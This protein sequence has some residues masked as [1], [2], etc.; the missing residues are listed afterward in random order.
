M[1]TTAAASTVTENPEL[2]P[3]TSPLIIGGGI[4][5]LMAAVHLAERGL[6]PLV[7]EA[8]P[9]RPGG[10]LKGGPTVE[11]EHNGQPWRFPGEHGVHGIWSPY[12]NFQAALARHNLRPVFVP[13]REETWI[14]GR[15]RTIRKAAIGSAIRHS[16][17][18]A[19]FHYLHLFLR[20]RFLNILTLRDLA[21]MF[22]VF[23]GLMSAMSIDPI[24]EQKSLRGL[25]LADFTAGWSP[26]LASFFAG[27]VRSALAAHPTE[28]PA[29]GFIA[30]LRFYT[31]LRRDAWA[32]SYLPGSGGECV[33][34]P[35]ATLVRRLGGEV[36]LG[37]RVERLEVGRLEGWK[38]GGAEG[39]ESR[40]KSG[41]LD[42]EP[43]WEVTVQTDGQTSIIKAARVILAVDAPAAKK[44]LQGSPA[45]AEA[46]AGLRFPSGVPTAIIR[47]WFKVK[48]KA[49]AEAGI[50][51]GD[52]VMDNFFWL[53]RLQTVYAE[54][55]RTTGGSAIE[56]HIYGPPELLAQP[57]ASLLARVLIDTY[58]VFPELRGN[59]LHSRLLRNEASH[60]LFSVGEP[61]EHLGI[62]TP[63]PNLFACGDWVYHPAPALYLERATTTGVAAANAVLSSLGL[64]PWPL[65]PHPQPEWLAGKM[66]RSLRG[67]RARMLRRKK[68]STH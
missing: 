60:T 10:R 68:S 19:P 36:R 13:A 44:L 57:D 54:W 15:G 31:L 66:E 12:H 49:I 40:L 38:V 8:D 4:A 56:M 59:L 35:L 51:S 61:G 16:L 27:L 52:F 20:P 39:E 46:A 48:P 21:S 34:E 1:E 14:F 41:F 55:S 6:T 42:S 26:T 7:L 3:T 67:L 11:I 65:L 18:P 32:F 63:W 28:V 25:S 45:T 64:E 29:S 47:L 33:S 23:G 30:F 17:L 62:E 5:G 9:D 53:D 2:L 43:G 50:Y 37:A 24:A 22:R 58:R